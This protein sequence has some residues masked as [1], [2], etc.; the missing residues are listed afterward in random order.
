MGLV[1]RKGTTRG[2]EGWNF[3]LPGL[4]GQSGLEVEFNHT[5]SD[6][7]VHAYRMTPQ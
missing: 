5:A 3:K 2:F 7:N 6:G 4:Q 1:S